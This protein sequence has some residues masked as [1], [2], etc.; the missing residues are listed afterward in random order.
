MTTRSRDT[1]QGRSRRAGVAVVI[2]ATHHCMTTR[3][4]DKPGSLMV[5]SRLTGVFRDDSSVKREFLT[6]IGR[7]ST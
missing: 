4:V 6:L 7:S 2:E 5:T 1:I 3:G